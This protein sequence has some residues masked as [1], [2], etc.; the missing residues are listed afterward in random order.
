M[1]IKRYTVSILYLVLWVHARSSA[2][3]DPVTIP[4]PAAAPTGVSGTGLCM[5]SAV[6]ASPATD[7]GFLNVGNYNA[8][9]NTFIDSHES[10]R[11]EAVLR[12]VFDLSNNNASGTQASFGDFRDSMSPTCEFG[13]CDFPINDTT[14]SFGA[15]LR[16]YLDVSG[17]MVGQ[18]VHFGFYVDD[19]VSL[20]LYDG[21]GNT[22]AVKVRPPQLGLPTWRMTESVTFEQPGLYPLEILYVEIAEH[23]ALE[24][25]YFIGP[26]VDFERPASDPPV[27]ELNGAGFTLFRPVD[28]FQAVSGAPSF[29]NLDQCQQCDRQFAN[30]PNNN[31]CD[32]NYYC[33]DAALCAPCDTALFCGPSCS[34]CGGTESFCVDIGGEYQCAECREDSDCRPGYQCDPQ[35][36]TC[37]EC[38]MDEECP[39]GQA[40]IDHACQTCATDDACAGTSCNCCPEGTRCADIEESGNPVCVQ[41][42][43]DSDC[44]HGVCD[45]LTGHCVEQVM[46]NQSNQCC[47]ANCAQCPER[48]PHCL[49]GPL[50]AACAECR[51]DSDCPDS[52][53][54]SSGTCIPC[55]RDRRCGA[56]CTS[57][58][59]DTPYCLPGQT[60]DRSQ[61]VECTDD[62]HCGAGICDQ[63]TNQCTDTCSQSCAQQ[64]PYC[65]G[66]QCVECM[67][68]THCGCGGTC[69]LNTYT[70]SSSCKT[71]IDCLGNEHCRWDVNG[72]AKECALGPMPDDA[73]CGT[74]L[75]CQISTGEYRAGQR[76]TWILYGLLLLFVIVLLRR[77]GESCRA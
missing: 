25:S 2:W 31:G 47:G 30:V 49:P 26:G 77:G 44:A 69:D 70:C 10:D 65:L 45:L 59:D 58:G 34:R 66:E 5:A 7:F 13:G 12:T 62:A 64:T 76:G 20:T 48:Y 21:S 8:S 56:R 67:A 32:L 17:D 27:I 61:C 4:T 68:D 33:N 54:C 23:A 29:P 52:W 14:T 51:W 6:S 28:F 39:R 41:C 36:F 46:Q 22:Y 74:T 38:N 53:F 15:R 9:L 24:M 3:A 60:P 75:S 57:C 50:G 16:G 35:T 55:S 43:A 72:R 1:F 11:T 73:A 71:N 18:P 37:H 40:C 19:A 42:L 63:A